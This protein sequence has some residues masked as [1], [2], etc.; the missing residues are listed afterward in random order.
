MD[1]NYQNT[2]NQAEEPVNKQSSKGV[3]MD[4]LSGNLFTREVF[5]RQLPFIFFLVFLA[6]V[7]IANSYNAEKLRWQIKRSKEELKGLR[8]QSLSTAS[9]LMYLSNQTEVLKLVAKKGLD[10]NES[11]EPPK[12]IVIE[13]RV[14]TEQIM[15]VNEEE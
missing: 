5:I 4:I 7:Q 9:E 2:E 1:E 12:K 8:A 10:L 14:R 15:K 13:K 3:I 6:F 11:V